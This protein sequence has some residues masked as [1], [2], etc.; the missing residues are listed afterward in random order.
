MVRKKTLYLF[1]ILIFISV[2]LTPGQ[3]K[4]HNPS[5]MILGYD[6]IDDALHV[7]IFHSS[8]DFNTHYIFEVNIT[9]NGDSV[10][11]SSHTSQPSNSSTYRY[12]FA[13]N[14]GD[15]IEVTARCTQGGI[16]T[17]SITIGQPTEA[18]PGFIGLWFV[19]GAS[20]ILMII[21]IK[22]K[23]KNKVNIRYKNVILNYKSKP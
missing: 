6:V 16:I 9:L 10:V 15:V 12:G 20:T 4:A 11:S 2:L 5:N 3:V 7:V 22:K 23:V 17:R 14:N 18:I 19:V 13:A 8:E 21:L 1:G